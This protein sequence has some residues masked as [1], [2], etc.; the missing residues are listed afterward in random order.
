MFSL[1]WFTLIE[2]FW[3]FASTYVDVFYNKVA[4]I[5]CY[6]LKATIELYSIPI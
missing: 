3:K 5:Y 1:N 6:L 2:L 4:I